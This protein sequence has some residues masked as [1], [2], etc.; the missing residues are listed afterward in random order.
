MKDKDEL[1]RDITFG[2]SEFDAS[3]EEIAML[4]DLFEEYR[5][6]YVGE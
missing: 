6:A 3:Q 5:D 2:K 1:I 4:Y